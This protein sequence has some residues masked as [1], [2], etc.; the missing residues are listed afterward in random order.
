MIVDME[1]MEDQSERGWDMSAHSCNCPKG[2]SACPVPQVMYDWSSWVRS[3]FQGGKLCPTQTTVLKP[4]A[5][6]FRIPKTS[7]CDSPV[8]TQNNVEWEQL[9]LP[10][11]SA[12]DVVLADETVRS[13]AYQCRHD[14]R[15]VF[16][17][18]AE[19]SKS[20]TTTTSAPLMWPQD[21]DCIPGEWGSWGPCSAICIEESRTSVPVKKRR[22]QIVLEQSGAGRQCVLETQTDCT[23]PWDV[24]Y[25][26]NTC[27]RAE[28]GAWSDC[29][30][31]TWSVG[32]EPQLERARLRHI[33]YS[34]NAECA[35]QKL[36]QRDTSSCNM[37][38]VNEEIF[39]CVTC[40]CWRA[41]Y[42]DPVQ[43]RV[44]LR[45]VEKNQTEYCAVEQQRC[46][47]LTTP[48]AEEEEIDCTKITAAYPVPEEIF[49]CQNSCRT[50]SQRCMQKVVV[51]GSAHLQCVLGALQWEM[52]QSA[53]HCVYE[54][55]AT[56]WVLGT[57]PTCFL[58][59]TQLASTTEEFPYV[60]TAAAVE[61]YLAATCDEK[62]TSKH[63]EDFTTQQCVDL[64]RSL[65]EPCK[66]DRLHFLECAKEILQK[67]EFANNC[68]APQWKTLGRGLIFCKHVPKNCTFSSWSEWT[69]C[70]ATCKETPG[71]FTDVY[72]SRQRTL[73]SPSEY[74][75]VCWDASGSRTFDVEFCTWLPPCSEGDNSSPPVTGPSTSHDVNA[76]HPPFEKITTCLVVDMCNYSEGRAYSAQYNSCLCPDGSRSCTS[77]E[78]MEV[79]PKGDLQRVICSGSY[80]KN[81][82]AQDGLKFEC[83]TGVFSPYHFSADPK[84]DCQ[85]YVDF[86]FCEGEGSTQHSNC[87]CVRVVPYVTSAVLI[88]MYTCEV[89]YIRFK[90][91]KGTTWNMRWK[92]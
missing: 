14:I 16:C 10:P 12:E 2:L 42:P 5:T 59:G 56:K 13:G 72:R 66:A 19:E 11:Y 52:L 32:S 31:T 22:R 75:G 70:S 78:V 73:L 3:L 4:V 7:L 39:H 20:T 47:D 6:H 23:V 15:Y 92:T 50:A 83:A 34:G 48:C 41:D 62:I 86:L 77:K 74:L 55:E 58:T 68:E 21:R 51:P 53:R 81:V 60:R 65:I 69:S 57:L 44:W 18:G 28:W 36:I 30:K 90:I 89:M 25:C 35:N 1:A 9:P 85:D 67:D 82:Y 79:I 87:V 61:T 8:N 24:D 46:V 91:G 49:A 37:R 38:T 26:E 84:A 29:A 80:H 17:Q 76:S 43:Y 40:R 33:F 64:C 88:C 54:A 45:P 27:W 63:K 71:T